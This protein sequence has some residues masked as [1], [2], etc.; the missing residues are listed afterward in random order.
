MNKEFDDILYHLSKLDLHGNN[1]T[2]ISAEM[3]DGFILTNTL[4]YLDLSNN[5]ISNLPEKIR[6]LSSIKTLKISG[7]KFKCSCE[8]FWMREWLLNETQVVEDFENVKCQMKSGKWIPVVHMDKADMG[9]FP[10][11][12][13]PLSTWQIAG[14]LIWSHIF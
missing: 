1:L 9:C 10:I 12:G 11:T 4:L 14:M 2:N 13:E 6:N 3:F 5:E 7:N 8:T